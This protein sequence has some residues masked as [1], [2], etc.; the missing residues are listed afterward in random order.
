MHTIKFDIVIFGKFAL[1]KTPTGKTSFEMRAFIISSVKC[2]TENE[3]WKYNL[4][5]PEILSAINAHVQ[6]TLAVHLLEIRVDLTADPYS[7]LAV[8]I[9]RNLCLFIAVRTSVR[10]AFNAAVH[11]SKSVPICSAVH[12]SVL[13]DNCAAFNSA[14][15]LEICADPAVLPPRNSCQ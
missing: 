5:P 15:H 11:T 1:D 8:Q 12:Q 10:T 2:R 9:S 4:S 7:K 13:L 6:Q 3:R 14:V